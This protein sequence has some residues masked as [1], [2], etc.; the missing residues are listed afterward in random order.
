[1]IHIEDACVKYA[2]SRL[3]HNE[4]TNITKANLP[5]LN[6]GV[7]KSGMIATPAVARTGIT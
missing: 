1:M 7:N 2:A 3:L 6:V 5:T 4:K